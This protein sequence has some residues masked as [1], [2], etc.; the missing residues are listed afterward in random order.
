MHANNYFRRLIG[1]L[2]FHVQLYSFYIH[3][4]HLWLLFLFQSLVHDLQ[5]HTN[6]VSLK[7]TYRI[8]IIWRNNQ[9]CVQVASA[10]KI[11]YY[12]DHIFNSIKTKSMISDNKDHLLVCYLCSKE[13]IAF[14]FLQYSALFS[15]RHHNTH[16]QPPTTDTGS[17]DYQLGAILGL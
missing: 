15:S 1:K 10:Y 8:N 9:N 12:Y 13:R 11:K 6:Y 14:H 5:A 17:R 3:A 4:T 7:S 2:R 16:H